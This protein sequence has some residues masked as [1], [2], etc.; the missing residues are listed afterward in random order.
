[1]A[2]FQVVSKQL[3][4]FVPPFRSVVATAPIPIGRKIPL[5]GRILNKPGRHSIR[6]G[7]QQHILDPLGAFIN[8]SCD[9]TSI[10]MNE[11]GESFIKVIKELDRGDEL[12]FNYFSSEDLPIEYGFVCMDC[13]KFVDR[14]CRKHEK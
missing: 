14:K 9:P 11:D 5:W 3:N 12:T 2:F 10:I 7:N 13:R 4:R 8:H 6:I 1:M